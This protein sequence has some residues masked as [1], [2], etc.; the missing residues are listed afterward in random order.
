M[1]VDE[2]VVV[3]TTVASDQIGSPATLTIVTTSTSTIGETEDNESEMIDASD[4]RSVLGDPSVPGH[5]HHSHHPAY[6]PVAHHGH[7]G[8]AVAHHAHH[9]GAHHPAHH[10]HVHH[11]G[12]NGRM[13]PPGFVQVAAQQGSYATLTPLQPLPPI[14]TMS[15]KFTTHHPYSHQIPSHQQAAAAAA[16]HQQL[17]AAAAAAANATG[18]AALMAHH[19]HA[20]S[21]AAMSMN[22]DQSGQ[23]HH[24]LDQNGGGHSSNQYAQHLQRNVVGLASGPHGATQS[25]VGQQQ[26]YDSAKQLASMVSMGSPMSCM[27]SPPN[28]VSSQTSRHV[29]AAVAALINGSG[30]GGSLGPQS[31]ITSVSSM[32]SNRTISGQNGTNGSDS[33]GLVNLQSPDRSLG[34][35]CSGYDYSTSSL[36]RDMT[37][38]M[39]SPPTS[40]STVRSVINLHSPSNLMSSSLNGSV[41]DSITTTMANSGNNQRSNSNDSNNNSPVR[42]MACS[43]SPPP[44]QLTVSL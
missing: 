32:A 41:L 27:A 8:G 20:Q 23:M 4:F 12:L 33:V 30:G 19:M 1:V 25:Q 14:S 7:H 5:P 16:H 22:L 44:G 2:E 29:S 26:H 35:P 36:V 3:V 10:P 17:Q 28:S 6:H 37:S 40:P 13:T 38:A 15:D 9:P 39:A 24:G 34:S 42:H 18:H 43:P 21:A 11:Q 31:V